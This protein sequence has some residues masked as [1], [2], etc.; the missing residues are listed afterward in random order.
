MSA[1][2]LRRW[3]T[4]SCR[5]TRVG[6]E[7][8]ISQLPGTDRQGRRLVTARFAGLRTWYGISDLDFRFQIGP[9]TFEIRRSAGLAHRAK[10]QKAS[11]IGFEPTASTLTGW[12]ALQA[13]PR[14]RVRVSGSG[15]SR[16]HSIPGSKPRWSA[17]CL[18]SHLSC[19]YPEQESNL[20]TSGFKPDRSATW[21]T[22]ARSSSPGGMRTTP[23]WMGARC[24]SRWTTGR[25]DFRFQ[26]SDFRFQISDFILHPS[27]FILHPSSFR[28]ILSQVL[29]S[30]LSATRLSSA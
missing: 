28:L 24:R 22:W 26:I 17:S 23:A 5:V 6:V 16:T 21:R 20:Q 3:T 1:R 4:G 7:P 30:E 15:G 29:G 11:P 9:R 2:R 19:Q 25:L 27:S 14:G 12:R 18:P 10:L 13:A 8:T